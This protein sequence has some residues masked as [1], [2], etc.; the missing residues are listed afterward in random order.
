V[1]SAPIK[2]EELPFKFQVNIDEGDGETEIITKRSLV[3][4]NSQKTYERMRLAV[5]VDETFKSSVLWFT[6]LMETFREDEVELTPLL[7]QMKTLGRELELIKE[8][9]IREA[10][11]MEEEA[12]KA[13][14]ASRRIRLAASTPVKAEK[15]DVDPMEL[16]NQVKENARKKEE[17]KE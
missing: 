9:R 2:D 11:R 16:F 7:Y 5:R 8:D 12:T 10:L 4:L 1:D 17:N 14:N 6:R 3:R 15:I 13:Y